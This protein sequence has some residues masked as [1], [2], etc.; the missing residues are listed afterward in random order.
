MDN[1]IRYIVVVGIVIVLIQL[2]G[3]MLYFVVGR[4]DE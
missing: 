1:S 4:R 3:P 2:V